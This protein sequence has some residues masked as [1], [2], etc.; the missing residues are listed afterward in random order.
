M[1]IKGAW[2]LISNDPNRFGETFTLQSCQPTQTTIF[3]DGPA[4]LYHV[5]VNQC[6][7]EYPPSSCVKL[8]QTPVSPNTI[9]SRTTN[10]LNALQ[11]VVG[12]AETI[13]VVMDGLA[14]SEKIPTQVQRL[15]QIAIQC[16]ETATT[17]NKS[18]HNIVHLLAECAMEQAVRHVSGVHLHRPTHGEA[19]PYIDHFIQ[20][21]S[22][23]NPII[24]SGDSDFFIYPHC[25]GFVPFQGLE[26]RQELPSS[27]S[28]SPPPLPPPLKHLSLTGFHYLS[29]KF[30]KAYIPYSP[31]MAT[32]IAALAGCD[33][34]TDVLTKARAKIVASDIAGLRQKQRMAPSH[35]AAL[36]AI[37]RYVGVYVKRYPT[38]WMV[39]MLKLLDLEEVADSL[40]QVY[41]IYFPDTALARND[42]SSLLPELQRVIDFRIFFCRPLVENC[43]TNRSGTTVAHLIK[44]RPHKHGKRK[45]K[46]IL[47]NNISCSLLENETG[48]CTLPIAGQVQLPYFDTETEALTLSDSVWHFPPFKQMRLRIYSIL[49]QGSCEKKVQEH[50]RVGKGFGT[51]FSPTTVSVPI[52]N[53][54]LEELCTMQ[55]LGYILGL[56]PSSSIQGMLDCVPSYQGTFLAALLLSPTTALMLFVLATHPKNITLPERSLKQKWTPSLYRL[57]NLVSVACYQVHLAMNAIGIDKLY[58]LDI[59]HTF[60]WKISEWIFDCLDDEIDSLFSSALDAIFLKLAKDFHGFTLDVGLLFKWKTDS[61]LLWVQWLVCHDLLFK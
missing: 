52:N 32:T 31:I 38:E 28:S 7:N 41:T 47:R 16:D 10:F 33:Y 54:P 25:L 43:G 55:T 45:R 13:H 30:W 17:T 12:S 5:N 37:L 39:P 23:K 51:G 18:K 24:M 40:V 20:K 3:L 15:K 50:C 22:I 53:A 36:I 57:L 4:L 59:S 48:L 42:E 44:R 35:A 26:W 34:G 29:R 60:S 46:H 21:Q 61:S 1:G 2:S 56:D 11:C 19:E 14:P 8:C 9:Y 49:L 27:S 6:Y 58:P